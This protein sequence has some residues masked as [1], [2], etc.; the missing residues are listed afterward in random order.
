[1]AA[2]SHF[3]MTK[4]SRVTIASAGL[5]CSFCVCQEPGRQSF[6]RKE[7]EL[8]ALDSDTVSDLETKTNIF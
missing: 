5:S 3:G 7:P 1:M 2:D 6:E 4:L 8:C